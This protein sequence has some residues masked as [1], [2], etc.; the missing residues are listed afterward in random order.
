MT[1]ICFGKHYEIS[2]LSIRQYAFEQYVM[3]FLA[4]VGAAALCVH[5]VFIDK[6]RVRLMTYIAVAIR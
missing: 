5:C 3:I 2:C 4:G 6:G 1:S